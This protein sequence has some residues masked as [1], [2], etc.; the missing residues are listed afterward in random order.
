MLL[1]IAAPAQSL[2]STPDW[3]TVGL[4]LSIVGS[5]FLATAILFRHPH[6][7]VREHF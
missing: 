1:A 5:F 3:V 6:S 7:L 4:V 2:F